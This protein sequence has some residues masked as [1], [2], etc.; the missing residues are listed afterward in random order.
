MTATLVLF[1]YTLFNTT[2]LLGRAAAFTILALIQSFVFVDFW[3]SHK[4]VFVFKKTFFSIPF[5]VAFGFPFVMQFAVMQTP[6]FAKI[7]NVETVTVPMFFLF[8][9]CASLIFV[10]IKIFNLIAKRPEV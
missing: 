6:E 3:V 5:L 8:A 7:F 4:S 2:E 10:G 1:G 9:A